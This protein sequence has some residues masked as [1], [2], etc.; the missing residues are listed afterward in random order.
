MDSAVGASV[1]PAGLALSLCESGRR[2]VC[3]QGKPLGQKHILRG[4]PTLLF[5][6]VGWELAPTVINLDAASPQC[7]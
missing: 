1:T 6:V 2:P 4:A 5:N 3:P 7:V